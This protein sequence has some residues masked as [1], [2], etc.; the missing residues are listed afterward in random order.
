M[1]LKRGINKIIYQ[2]FLMIVL[3]SKYNDL[4][5][6]KSLADEKIKLLE[7][8][9]KESEEQFLNC[10]DDNQLNQNEIDRLIK[11][12]MS[13]D[14]YQLLL[15]KL[16]T[17]HKLLNNTVNDSL[18]VQ[19][20]IQNISQNVQESAKNTN[21]LALTSSELG[22]LSQRSNDSIASLTERTNEIDSILSL[23]KDIADQTNLLALNAAIEAARAGEHGR[24]FAVVADE[25]RKLSDRTQHAV[26]D[27]SVVIKSI[28]QDSFDLT[29]QHEDIEKNISLTIT[30][31]DNLNAQSNDNVT[32]SSHIH[33]LTHKMVDSISETLKQLDT[34][35]KEEK[36]QNR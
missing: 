17:I 10:S 28:E 2:G 11:N 30:S 23:I 3:L 7:K 1:K 36:S 21:N 18:L 24:G 19:N 27:I 22:E 26:S 13:K 4:L 33:D 29:S 6:E 15:E 16:L 9:L 12:H 31:I 8:K 35:I 25:V 32:Q 34:I 5:H 14:Q 20:S